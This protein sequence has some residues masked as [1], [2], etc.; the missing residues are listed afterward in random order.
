MKGKIRLA[1]IKPPAIKHNVATND[2]NCK[3]DNPIM[4]WPDVHPPA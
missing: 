4:E 2:G 1:I 3:L